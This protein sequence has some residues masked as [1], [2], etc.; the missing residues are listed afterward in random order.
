M[1]PLLV[2]TTTAWAG[3]LDVMLVRMALA[4][5]RRRSQRARELAGRLG[6]Y[7]Q[8]AAEYA[9]IDPAEFYAKPPPIRAVRER[10]VRRTSHGEIVAMAW[11]SGYEPR[12]RS[13]RAGFLSH[14]ENA[15]VH[16]HHRRHRR[17]AATII[18]IP[19]YR[20][21]SVILEES[22]W[23][24]KWLFD[25]GLDVVTYTLPFHGPRAPRRPARA[26]IFPS[27][28]NIART[29]EG[30]G[31]VAWELRGLVHWLRRR[32]APAVGLAGMS[33]GGY[34]ASLLAT[35]EPDLDFVVAFTPLADITDAVVAHEAMR[36]LPIDPALAAA[37]RRAL[38]IHQ[39]LCRD[40]ILRGDRIAVV[41][42][43]NDRVTGRAH[44]ERLARHFAAQLTL[45]P[46]AHIVQIGR[47]TGFTAIRDLLMRSGVLASPG[48]APHELELPIELPGPE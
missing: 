12:L 26:P 3:M 10:V 41:G 6:Y 15:I 43:E 4:A 31:Q 19:G 2:R 37:S 27:Q 9:A 32:G 24:A 25:L 16:V 35:V 29:N 22:A 39:P 17:P 20:S 47:G 1:G 36:G 30:F 38:A 18:C 8:I 13:A 42:A 7:E 48:P 45:F 11:P 5:T 21:S 46:G 23:R 34:A 40:P 33:M 28:G 14:Q 44:A